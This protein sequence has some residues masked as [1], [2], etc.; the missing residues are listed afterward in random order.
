MKN[1]TILKI[2]IFAFLFLAGFFVSQKPAYAGVIYDNLTATTT[3]I[4]SVQVFYADVSFT[5]YYL[6]LKMCRTG[7]ISSD[8][9]LNIGKVDYSNFSNPYTCPTK[10]QLKEGS[11]LNQACGMDYPFVFNSRLSIAEANANLPI[12][13]GSDYAI[14]GFEPEGTVGTINA[15]DFYEITLSS[16]YGGHSV[17]ISQNDAFYNSYSRLET[18]IRFQWPSSPLYY[19]NEDFYFELFGNLTGNSILMEFPPEI[20]TTTYKDFNNWYSHIYT[21]ATSTNLK[22]RYHFYNMTDTDSIAINMDNLPSSMTG[23]ELDYMS[24][25]INKLIDGSYEAYATIDYQDDFLAWHTLATSSIS[26]FTIDN[27]SGTDL[28]EWLNNDISSSYQNCTTTLCKLFSPS[29]EIKDKF[30]G[31]KDM[32]LEKPPLGYFT[33]LQS[34]FNKYSFGASSSVFASTGFQGIIDKIRLWTA[35]VFILLFTFYYYIRIKHLTL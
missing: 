19:A 5:P 15:D 27:A 10:Q 30:A 23:I 16:T 12:C 4:V 26:A 8:M 6:K 28:Y 3:A 17:F 21:D 11:Y 34:E 7:T 22:I 14:I 13:N 2:A 1:P 25:K 20:S 29:E 24:P 9:L 18:R 32:L 31:I 35:V 33:L